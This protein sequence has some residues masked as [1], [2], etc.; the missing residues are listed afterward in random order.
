[1]ILDSAGGGV[2]ITRCGAPSGPAWPPS[3][4]EC[5]GPGAWFSRSLSP[6]P[7][8]GV[9]SLMGSLPVLRSDP[10]GR[11]H[12]EEQQTE[13]G[14]QAFGDRPYPAK[15]EPARVRLLPGLRDVGD[16]VALFLRG[17]RRVVEDRH[18]LWPGQHGLE[19]LGGSGLRQRRRVL[20]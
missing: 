6:C 8:P 10:H 7:W 2:P 18:R 3:V 15:A 20:A 5:C 12:H 17:D 16:D 1:S 4:P 14:H 11:E 19:D 13:E 9:E